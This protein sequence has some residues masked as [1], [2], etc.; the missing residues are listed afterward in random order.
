MPLEAIIEADGRAPFVIMRPKVDGTSFK[1][2][3]D[4]MRILN[5]LFVT[6]NAL[7]DVKIIVGLQPREAP[8]AKASASARVSDASLAMVGTAQEYARSDKISH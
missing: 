6:S 4:V 5:S 8:G 3:A 2:M 7:R 1:A